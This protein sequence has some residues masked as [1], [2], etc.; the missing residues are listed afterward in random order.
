M[1]TVR[2][3][4]AIVLMAVA[5]GA[6][7]SENHAEARGGGR[8]AR[9]GFGNGALAGRDFGQLRQQLG[10]GRFAGLRQQGLSRQG[11]FGNNDG[12]LHAAQNQDSSIG[13]S[14]NRGIWNASSSASSG[15]NRTTA[16]QGTTPRGG[17]YDRT[18]EVTGG[19]GSGYDKTVTTTG[20][21]GKGG[22]Y[23]RTKEVTG[24]LGNGYDKTV[25]TTGTTGKGGTY[26]RT[27]EVTGGLGSG[28]DKTVTT[29][30]TTGKGGTYDRTKDV[31][32]GLGNGY[33]KTVTTTGTTG[34]GGAFERTKTVNRG[35]NSG[36]TA[37][38]GSSDSNS[39]Q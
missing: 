30:D 10:Q 4:F 20:T 34:K 29:T 38:D 13:S 23:D 9:A 24:G 19:L 6:S 25:T 35:G 21:T 27:K 26:D 17:T 32:A 36:S 11:R 5:A 1:S 15:I 12:Q 28:Y 31:T 16:N 3:S 7:F 33:D 14:P 18:K 2:V 39:M 22:T 8:G 37:D